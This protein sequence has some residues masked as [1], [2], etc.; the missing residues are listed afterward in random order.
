[1]RLM[2]DRMMGR[3][4]AWPTVTASFVVVVTAL[5]VLGFRDP[6]VWRR[7]F[8]A[9]TPS[10]ESTVDDE[11]PDEAAPEVD[12][13]SLTDADAI[14]VVQS[15]QFFSAE[16]ADA[17]RA[18]VAYLESLPHVD[19]VLWMD[20]VPILNIFGLPEPLL[21][22]STASAHRFQVAKQKALQH[23]LVA[24]QLLSSSGT[25]LLLMVRFDWLHVASDDDCIAGLRRAA[26]EKAAEYDVDF[27][28]HVTGRVPLTVVAMEQHE[29][30][31][32][33]YQLIGYGMIFVMALVLFR[34]LA[35]VIVV[36]LAPSMGVFWTLGIL[37]FFGLEDNPFNDVVLPVLLSLV[38]L[39]D[40]VHLMVQI[41]RHR[42]AGLSARESA[43][44]ALREVGLA[45]CLTSITTAI[46]FASLSLAHHEVVRDF[47]RSCVLGVLLT[48]FSVIT[49]IPLAC[50]TWLGR[51]VEAGHDRSPIDRNLNRI[52]VVVDWALRRRR[53]VSWV[54]VAMTVLLVA[55]S[56]SLRPDERNVN[57][58]PPSAEPVKAMQLMDREMGGLESSRVEIRWERGV[59]SDGP[60]VLEVVAAVDRLLRQEELISHPV[61]IAG[62]LNGLPGDGDAAERMTLLDLLP[63]PLKRAF[64][65]PEERFASVGF[66]VQDLGIRR[67]DPIFRR[68]EAGIASIRS[69]HP[70]FEI[71]L[72]GS[73]IWRWRNLFQI[74][75]DLAA[76]LGSATAVIL[77]VMSLAY[78][79]VR[80][81]LISLV[82]NLFPL[83]VTGA[84]LVVAG[85]SLEVV[86]VCA[87]TI[88]LGIAVDD[89]IHFLTRYREE[90]RKGLS[91]NEAIRRAFTGVG[92]ALI[93]TTTIL[94]AGFATVLFSGLRDHRIFAGMGGLTI[95][96]ALFGDMIFLP[97]MLAHFRGGDDVSHSKDTG[98]ESVASGS[99]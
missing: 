66:R 68:V 23:P 27:E 43:Q 5:A 47:G 71:E 76:S 50:C 6:D 79:S 26:A 16:G 91:E 70:R 57:M 86:S 45:C 74:V 17:M 14:L 49:V 44:L 83:A 2:F 97:A 48:F 7:W 30:N 12:E 9:E 87:F 99:P 38:G 61:S 21:P 53:W 42:V 62:L 22:R 77:L 88:C 54:G 29:N 89:S 13:L 64:Y 59:A 52:V 63:P 56:L 3:I 40:G 95:A 73:A 39:T 80:I 36:A 98:V 69:E 90:Q 28:F 82:P 19:S 25:T 92:T 93:M 18:V 65:V 31:Q 67:Y 81:G 4:V 94:V 34:G 24:G 85:Q 58:L 41:R 46:G 20:R 75:V 11:G 55:I 35:A 33:R 72:E 32:L 1:M 96:A 8:V 37:R 10:E 84:F 51:R 60:E 15:E 78:R